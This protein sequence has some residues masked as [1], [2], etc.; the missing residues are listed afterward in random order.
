MKILDYEKIKLK[1]IQKYQNRII[2]LINEYVNI[3]KKIDMDMYIN[4]NYIIQL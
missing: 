2:N 3:Y 1:Y 4:Y